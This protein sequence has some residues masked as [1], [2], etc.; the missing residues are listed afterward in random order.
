MTKLRGTVNDSSL[1]KLG[2]VYI[3]ITED[4]GVSNP[5][6][7]LRFVKDTT[8]SIVEG[9]NDFYTDA[10]YSN[11][12]GKT[13]TFTA[14]E[15][16]T[17]YLKNGVP[18]KISIPDKYSIN[19]ARFVGYSWLFNVNDLA[20]YA[21]DTINVIAVNSTQVYGSIDPFIKHSLGLQT[22]GINWQ[23]SGNISDIP[24]PNQLNN[25]YV[26]G[27]DS[28]MTTVLSTVKSCARLCKADYI[29]NMSLI[30][31]V[32]S[33]SDN[34]I[35]VLAPFIK[36]NALRIY[37][38]EKVECSGDISAFANMTNLSILTIQ[39]S[40]LTGNIQSL[41]NTKIEGSMS[42]LCKGN[43]VSGDLSYIPSGIY[44]ISFQKNT[45][46]PLTWTTGK[47]GSTSAKALAL[48][49]ARFADGELDKFLIDNAKCDLTGISIRPESY[50]KIIKVS[51]GNRT[52][53]SD[54][55]VTT[56]Q[57]A[58]FTLSI[59]SASSV[60]LRSSSKWGIAYK[61]KELIVE[62]VNL[63]VQTIYPAPDVTVKEFTTEAEA[64]EFISLQGLVR[65]E[66]K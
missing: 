64:R 11:K 47:R 56:L 16:K 50:A 15:T 20:T 34:D 48:E 19:G 49:D 54:S 62:P 21:D 4:V 10:N 32:D 55:A 41:A 35:S 61:D 43:K 37:K 13:A 27:A 1:L 45:G 36:I 9:D 57:E 22:M 24:V 2:E 8:I 65:E 12:L 5:M 38:T 28:E 40:K 30:T 31:T 26:T 59:P 7:E 58:G 23:L 14:N 25:L 44:F 52:S 3:N 6:M 29:Y 63:S 60:M 46:S 39:S 17:L 53:A 66:S 42:E 18:C 51:S 33:E